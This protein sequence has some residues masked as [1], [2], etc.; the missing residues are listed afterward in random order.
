MLFRPDGLGSITELE[1]GERWSG[2]RLGDEVLSRA[3]RLAER[4]IGPGSRVLIAHG[5]SAAFFA[6][7]LAVWWNGA[8]AAVIDPSLTGPELANL[9]V[10]LRAD[11]ILAT[12]EL[13]E[14]LEAPV[15]VASD[16]RHRPPP[17]RPPARGA[18]DDP[19]L[20]LFT[21]GTTG[22]PKGVVHGFRSL[23]ARTALNRAVGGD[24]ALRRSLCM[25]PTHFGHG[26]IG[27]S[28]TPLLAGHV[29]Y[30]GRFSRALV[31]ALPAHL[32]RL[33]I[34]FLSS[35]PTMWRMI[36][37]SA[38]SPGAS[39]LARIHVGSAPL[40]AELWSEVVAWGATR[41]VVNTYGITEAAN[42]IG[43]ASAAEHEPADGLIG[44]AWGGAIA[45][46]EDSGEIR[47]SGE[48]EL[49]VASPSLMSGYLER[50]DLSREALAGGWFRTGD[51]G[52]VDRRGV[53]RLSGRIKNEI[54][55]GGAK[56]QPEDVDLVI[57]RHPGVAES[58]TFALSDALR[59][60]SVAAA[61]RARADV[62]LDVEALAAW[63]QDR[64]RAHAVP[65][66]WFVVEEIPKSDRGKV[67]RAV[68][69]RQCLALSGSPEGEA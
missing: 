29:L 9:T 3:G 47:S 14:G 12:R 51:L 30:L 7:L 65:E 34:T 57:E 25:L 68:V 66:R 46:R 60:Q 32:R 17:S 28:L 67:N 15:L 6:D 2:E 62:A 22:E 19:A 52:S 40:S 59:G 5:Q 11:L 31:A 13:G 20:V 36:L 42:W 33:G 23:L 58:C 21:S 35:V 64:M 69:R 16:E 39:E 37:E 48:G 26:L 63:C 50:P 8:C 24:Q 53:A 49:V 56:V 44:R 18:L 1:S 54:N 45:V 10:F 27:N 61:V 4:G 55:R 41:E 43:G 38:P